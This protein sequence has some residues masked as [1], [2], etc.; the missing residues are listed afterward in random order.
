MCAC[1]CVCVSVTVFVSVCVSVCVYTFPVPPTIRGG[2]SDLPDEVTVLVN[3]T[4][5]LECYADGN[6]APKITWLKD[7]QP[8]NTEGP[9]RMFSNGRILQV[10]TDYKIST[11]HPTLD[12]SN[13]RLRGC[14]VPYCSFYHADTCVLD[15]DK[16]RAC[17][18]AL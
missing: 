14:V 3:K 2:D 4:T 7:R 15:D 8:I 12:D 17:V 10:S 9:Y 11:L 6:P 13:R 16:S 1:V 18:L 5:Q